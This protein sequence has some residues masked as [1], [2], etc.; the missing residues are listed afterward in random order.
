ML[1]STR[2]SGV[3]LWDPIFG[4]VVSDQDSAGG[5]AQP[6]RFT[7]NESGFSNRFDP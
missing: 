6:A 3:G 5:F 1:W 2:G 7:T 4:L